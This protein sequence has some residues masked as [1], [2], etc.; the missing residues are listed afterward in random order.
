MAVSCPERREEQCVETL[1][2]L[3]ERV[4]VQV[5]GPPLRLREQVQVEWC[6][7][8]TGVGESRED[9]WERE[10]E[11]QWLKVRKTRSAYTW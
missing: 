3:R 2:R 5:H 9:E 4:P 11:R 1:L 6:P 10:G 7:R 8:G